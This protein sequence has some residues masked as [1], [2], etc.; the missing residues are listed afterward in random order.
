MPFRY[1]VDQAPSANPDMTWGKDVLYGQPVAEA[2]IYGSMS[3][4][5]WRLAPIQPPSQR[6]YC[7]TSGSITM[8][9]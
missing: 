2:G 1:S 5:H 3:Q 8:K 4:E 6:E 9:A 7:P